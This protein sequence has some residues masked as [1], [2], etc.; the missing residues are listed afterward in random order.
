MVF[1]SLRKSLDE[2]LARH[3]GPEERNVLV[4]RMKETLVRARMGL[5]DL[6]SGIVA[7]RKRLDAEQRELETVERRR[8]LAEQ[9][10]D[11]ETMKLADQYRALHA[12]KV[13]VLTRKLEAQESE[14]AIAERE[15]AD[16]TRE[17]KESAKG[18][19]GAAEREAGE[20]AA[21]SEELDQ[22]LA[23]DSGAP[24]RDEI[25]SMARDRH[26]AAREE[27]AARKLDELKRRMGR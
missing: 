2:L 25:D 8:R 20:V 6:R 26:R 24:L 15:V 7:S 3:T 17:L 5:D 16:M 13:A 1:D 11:A 18:I 12:E 19:P 14:L 22:E 23:R 10:G 4:A 21:A 27:D 9:I